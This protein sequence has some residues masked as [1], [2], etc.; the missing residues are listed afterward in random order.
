MV[1]RLKPVTHALIVP[2][3][4]FADPQRARR[5]YERVETALHNRGINVSH[6]KGLAWNDPLGPDANLRMRDAQ[7][8]RAINSAL[9]LNDQVVLLGDGQSGQDA[10]AAARAFSRENPGK[11]AAVVAVS[12]PLSNEEVPVDVRH[13]DLSAGKAPRLITVFPSTGDDQVSSYE[14]T[15]QGATVVSYGESVASHIHG[16]E[17]IL[18]D[19]TTVER[20]V[21]HVDRMR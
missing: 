19:P 5:T 17:D 12:S 14:A 15:L 11:V 9:T 13:A 10:F 2:G 6:I 4:E 18:S 1:D 16:V 20:I 3:R 21:W 7:I 8:Q